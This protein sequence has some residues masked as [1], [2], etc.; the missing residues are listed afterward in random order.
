MFDDRIYKRGALTLHALRGVLG[1]EKFFEL[2]RQWTTKHRHST[3]STEQFTD[4]A[5]RFT[6]TPLR[7]LWDAWLNQRPLPRL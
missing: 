2:I 5:S 6:D 1:D 4:L 3:V 7:P